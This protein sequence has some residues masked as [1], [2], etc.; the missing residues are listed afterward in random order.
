MHLG[1]AHTFDPS[2]QYKQLEANLVYRV[3]SRAD[4]REGG[5]EAGRKLA[6]GQSGVH[7]EPVLKKQKEQR[8]SDA[9]IPSVILALLH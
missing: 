7:R 5:R 3:R 6:Q 2:T 4:G 9:V 8:N 1:V